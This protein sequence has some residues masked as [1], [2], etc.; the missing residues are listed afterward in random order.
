DPRLDFSRDVP[1]ESRD[2]RVNV[3]F[4]TTRAPAPP[5]APERFTSRA[6]KAVRLGVAQVQLGAPGWSFDDLV[7]SDRASRPEAPRP[8]RVVSV[9]EFAAFGAPGREAEQ[10]FVSAIDRQLHHSPRGSTVIYVPGYRAT[11]DQVMVLMGSWAHFLGHH[12]P[13]IAFSWP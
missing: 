12:S 3:L 2:T 4:A 9:Q 6:G 5:E 7:A 13:V 11:F 8:A 1:P 10:E